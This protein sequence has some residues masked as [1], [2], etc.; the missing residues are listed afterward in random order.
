MLAY[1]TS[2]PLRRLAH[3]VRQCHAI[4]MGPQVNNQNALDSRLRSMQSDGR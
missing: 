3:R 1:L 4:S 2:A